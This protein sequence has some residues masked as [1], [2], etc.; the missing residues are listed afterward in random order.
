MPRPIAYIRFAPPQVRRGFTLVELLVVIAIIGTLIALLLPAV[1]SARE[2]GRRSACANNL[3][4]LGL[5]AL[6]YESIRG[7]FAPGVLGSQN[8]QQ[9]Q[10]FAE[11]DGRDN[12]WVG[13]LGQHLPYIE[14]GPVY[15]LL[16]TDMQLDPDTYDLRFFEN[17]TATEAAGRHIATFLCPS[18]SGDRPSNGVVIQAYVKD[19]A[20]GSP[21]V[22]ETEFVASS[23]LQHA[24]VSLPPG[25]EP[26]DLSGDLF[27]LTHYQGVWGVFGELGPESRVITDSGDEVEVDE[28]LG[29]YS[30][31]S[32][33]RMGEI[34]DGAS[35]TLLFGEAPGSLGGGFYD[36]LADRQASGYAQGVAWI[37]NCLTPTYQGL[38]G[39]QPTGTAEGSGGGDTVDAHWSSFGSCHPGIVQFCFADGSLRGLN[40]EIDLA[41]FKSLSTSQGGE[42]VSE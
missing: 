2:A 15:D 17:P 3:R 41:L 36:D 40:R 31:R 24:A 26:G 30:I 6:A 13:V 5:G 37:S 35:N 32:K 12:Q 33:T 39:V 7:Q 21:P 8:Y 16:T 10:S 11:P 19:T 28:R 18:I 1:Q 4:Q 22:D 34:T 27:G 9:P 25:G 38:N 20:K 14:Q 42:L 29:V 23:R